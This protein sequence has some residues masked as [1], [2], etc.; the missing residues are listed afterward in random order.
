VTRWFVSSAEIDGRVGGTYSISWGEG[1]DGTSDITVFEPER[2]LQVQHRPTEG[3]PPLSTGPM[4]EEYFIERDGDRTVLR[5]VTSGIPDT[6]DWDWFYEGTKR[7]WRIFLLGLRHYLENHPGTPREQ[8]VEMIG[9]TGSCEE[10]WSLLM[11][12]E[13]LDL[14]GALEGLAAGDRYSGRTSFGEDLGG[15]ILLLDPP[16]RLLATVDGLNGALL[17]A[18]IE[19]MGPTNFLHLAVSTFALA[20]ER[21]ASLRSRWS[22]WVKEAFPAVEPPADAFDNMITESAGS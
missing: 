6:E 13:G 16:Y 11:G 19:Q 17:S 14:A 4:I 18:T 1:M 12:A 7:G 5:L 3:Q 8:F 9:L 10:G 22:A 15:E 21:V 20:P 2:H